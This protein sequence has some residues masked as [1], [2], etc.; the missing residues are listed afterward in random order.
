MARLTTLGKLAVLLVIGGVIFLG[1][2][3]LGNMGYLGPRTTKESA[4]IEKVDLPDA[5]KN[6]STS[7]QP[8]ALP[9]KQ[10]ANVNSPE[11]RWLHW[12]WN[13]QMGAILANGGAQTTQGSIMASKKVNLKMTRQDDVSQM[14]AAL[15]KFAESYKSDP[16]TRDGAHFV[17]IM[18]DGAAAFL[19]GVN[20]QL[21]KLGEDYRAQIVFTCGRSLGEDKFMGPP[22]WKE[23][24]QAA[25]GG[26]TTAVLRDGD[27]N[28]VIKWCSDNGIPVNADETTYDPEAMNFIAA[29]T[30]IDASEKYINGY[31]EERDEVKKGQR[32]GKK[33]T[34]GVTGVTTWTPGDVMVAKKKGGLISIVSTKEYRSQMP[35]VLI[36]IKKWM[37]DNP[38]LVENLIEGIALGGD[39]VKSFSPA[40]KKAA[41]I[42]AEIYNEE[43]A[44]YW[45]KYYKGVTETDRKG[46]P[47][48][49][50]GSRVNNLAD[51]AEI[52]G[53]NPGSTN[54]IKIVYTTFGDIVKKLYPDLV[55]SY[56]SAEQVINTRFLKSVLSRA[57]G[58]IA[59]ADETEF[60]A[61]DNIRETVSKKSWAI[62]FT[63]GSAEFT[64]AAKVVMEQLFN[65]L[66]IASNLKVEVHGHTDNVG[67]PAANLKL[68][69]RRAFAI[70][71]WL[72]NKSA[73]N[74]PEGRISV[75]AHGA[76]NPLVTN[77]TPLGRAK[78]RRVEIIMGK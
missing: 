25:R 4:I 40:L 28:I 45:E 10:P 14:Q 60:N 70:K 65:D 19:A 30:Y 41:E 43:S 3:V 63:S 23:N 74:F 46:L 7:V 12:A 29:D 73:N 34:V 24:P 71:S 35:C 2:K 17:T 22:A 64:P 53:I 32:T 78:N 51:N 66:V 42:S 50:G 48:E 11:I 52:F 8:L 47:V 72:E 76:S 6:A 16:D 49:L 57:G 31:T 9:G 20:P 59:S 55:P 56:P 1:V 37:E 15:V 75:F 13:A 69:E 44:E 61:D 54:I 68:S 21:E 26:V 18:G 39:Q 67:D 38:R 36:G 5:P 77:D 27:W 33:V 58:D 62:E